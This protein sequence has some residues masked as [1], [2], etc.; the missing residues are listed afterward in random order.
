MKIKPRFLRTNC[1]QILVKITKP[2]QILIALLVILFVIHVTVTVGQVFPWHVYE[3][4]CNPPDITCADQAINAPA[5]LSYRVTF[6]NIC[7]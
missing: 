4:R 2:L 5:F 1:F 7:S 6:T 3:L